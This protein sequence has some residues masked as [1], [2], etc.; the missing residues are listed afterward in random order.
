M[1]PRPSQRTR[2]TEAL[3]AELRRDLRPV[4]PIPRL[5]W[6]A[7]TLLGLWMA[8]A[9]PLSIW[10]GANA[11]GQPGF[12]PPFGCLGLLAGGGAWA[13]LSCM[14]PGRDAST[15]RG[16]ALA[17]AGLVGILALGVHQIAHDGLAA[18]PPATL[19]YLSASLYYDGFCV[20]LATLL[21]LP[22]WSVLVLFSR[23]SWVLRPRSVAL[24][25]SV[26][27]V[28]AGAL[29]VHAICGEG[30]ARHA[31]GSHA[32]A[33]AWGGLVLLPAALLALRSRLDPARS[34]DA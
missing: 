26:A 33:P 6:V 16:M 4:R 31:L 20:G 27:S 11:V 21:A 34:L 25:A 5:R 7:L 8:L 18:F 17:A 1:T 24:L 22:I 2:S 3:I 15:R 19:D 23:R 13:T 32:L 14:V 10:P 29:I 30:C 28:G 12:L 9:L